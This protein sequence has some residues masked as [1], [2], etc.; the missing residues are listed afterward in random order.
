MDQKNNN[1]D[2]VEAGG[3]IQTNMGDNGYFSYL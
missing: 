1:P 3:S 2:V